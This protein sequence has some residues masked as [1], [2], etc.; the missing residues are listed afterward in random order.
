MKLDIKY[1]YN[2]AS[3]AEVEKH[4]LS[5]DEQFLPRLSSRVSILDY[6][7]KI[8]TYASLIEAWFDGKLIGLVAVYCDDQNTKIAHI[9]SVSVLITFTGNG[10]AGRLI[11]NCVEQSRSLG[12]HSINLEVSAQ[13]APAIALYKKFGFVS[14]KS[15]SESII[16]ALDLNVEKK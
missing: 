2:K 15:M 7:K 14:E 9:T 12:L 4:L 8:F 5:C 11:E 10:I 3:Q 6:A 16:M 1:K 13:N